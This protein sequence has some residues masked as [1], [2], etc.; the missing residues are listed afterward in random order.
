MFT[1]GV[2]NIELV[3]H[4]D[5]PQLQ[6]GRFCSIAGNVQIYLGAYHRSDWISTYPFLNSYSKSFEQIKRSGFPKSK[7]PVK[8]GND[9]W[10]GS[11]CRIMSGVSIGD[12]AIIS[13]GAHV[14]KDVEP[15]TIVGGNPAKFIKHRFESNIVDILMQIKWWNWPLNEILKNQDLLCST[16]DKENIHKLLTTNERIKSSAV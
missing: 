10:I 3:Y 8:I 12:G 15:Y 6:I 9:V 11:G 14:I 5:C 7:G 1:Y 4:E 13:A 2:Q 16:P